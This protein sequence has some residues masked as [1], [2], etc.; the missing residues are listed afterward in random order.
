MPSTGRLDLTAN[1]WEPFDYEIRYEGMDLTGATFAMDVRDRK[2]GGFVRA[3]LSTAV[4][5]A[6]E[7]VKLVSAAYDDVDFG[8]PIGVLNVPVSVIHIHINEPTVEAM[9]V[10]REAGEDGV[11]FY[12]LQATPSGG[13]KFRMIEGTFTVKAGSTGSGS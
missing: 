9:A 7:G 6:A 2:D 5:I 1:R 12:D 13:T 11:I 3:S 10:A 8:D 4:S